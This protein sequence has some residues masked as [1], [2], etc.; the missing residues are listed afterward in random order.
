[1]RKIFIPPDHLDTNVDIILTRT[2]SK[3]NRKHP[4]LTEQYRCIS[5]EVTFDYIEHKSTDEYPMHLRIVR[6]EVAE[7]VYENIITNL[8]ADEQPK[9]VYRNFI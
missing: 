9:M 3:K 7:G 6:F 8:P 2:H 4:E 1:M 5:S